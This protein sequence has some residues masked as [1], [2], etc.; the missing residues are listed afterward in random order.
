MAQYGT[1]LL[2]EAEPR[3]G[4][5][6]CGPM[7][8]ARKL[9][10][11]RLQGRG[12]LDEL[13][14]D[15]W[16]APLLGVFGAIL[17]GAGCLFLLTYYLSQPAMNPNPGV[18]AYTPPP[19][20]R[21]VPLPRK[22]DAPELADLPPLPTEP[23]PALTALAQAQP[24]DQPPKREARAPVRKRPRIDPRDDDQNRFGSVQPWKYG[25]R[26]WDNNRA[27]AGNARPWF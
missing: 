6:R 22:S 13:L 5:S 10:N 7:V 16:V 18:A 21:L 26:D 11:D 14:K 17:A 27:W 3:W 1:N 23:S 2:D 9:R 25:N 20:T 15:D 12:S 19:A 4:D 8:E 24:S